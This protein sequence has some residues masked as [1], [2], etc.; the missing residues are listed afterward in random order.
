MDSVPG[1]TAHLDIHTQLYKHVHK[2]TYVF[3]HMHKQAHTCTL[4]NMYTAHAHTCMDTYTN[5]YVYTHAH[6]H[7]P[8]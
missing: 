7:I 4:T 8:T 2:C 1:T 5:A 3:M 6:T